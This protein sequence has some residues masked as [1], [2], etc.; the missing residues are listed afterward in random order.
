MISVHFVMDIFEYAF[1][2]KLNWKFF[3]DRDLACLDPWLQSYQEPKLQCV[4]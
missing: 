4:I 3:K 1:S 2:P